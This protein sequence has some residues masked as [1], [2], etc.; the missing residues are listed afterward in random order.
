MKRYIITALCAFVVCWAWGQL[1]YTTRVAP[2]TQLSYN[3]IGDSCVELN[4]PNAEKSDVPEQPEVPIFYYTFILPTNCKVTSVEALGST[5]LTHTFPL[6]LKCTPPAMTTNGDIVYSQNND[7]PQYL[8]DLLYVVSDSYFDGDIHLVTIAYSPI[9]YTKGSRTLFFVRVPQFVVRYQN[10]TPDGI[11]PVTPRNR[12]YAERVAMIEQM[13]DNP[14]NVAAWI[15]ETPTVS[16][17]SVLLGSSTHLPGMGYEYLVITTRDLYNTTQKLIDWKR[18]KG[19]HAGVVCYED[20]RD[21]DITDTQTRYEEINDAA[22]HLRK[23]LRNAHANGLQYVFLVGER[24][25]IPYRKYYY[26]YCS[27][28]AGCDT[29]AVPTDFYYSELNSKWISK[30]DDQFNDTYDYDADDYASEIALGRLF[31]SNNEEWM[32]YINRLIT[33]ERNPGYGNPEYL[34]KYFTIQSDQMQQTN[35]GQKAAEIL[36]SYFSNIQTWEEEP[37]YDDTTLSQIYP[38]GKD[39]IDELQN[40]PCGYFATYAHGG[41]MSTAT[42]T[43]GIN[44]KGYHTWAIRSVEND[45]ITDAWSLLTNNGG[46]SLEPGAG[47]DRL[48]IPQNPFIVYSMSC[49]T[50][51]YDTVLNYVKSPDTRSY[52]PITVGVA[53]TAKSNSAIAYLGNTRVGWIGPSDNLHRA[54]NKEIL[55]GIYNLGLLEN[56]SK[57]KNISKQQYLSVAHNLLG[58][59]EIPMWT[60]IP[61]KITNVA[62]TDTVSVT[63]LFD[64]STP[65]TMLYGDVASNTIYNQ[66]HSIVK[67]KRNYYP[68]Y[69]PIK[70]QNLT[71]QSKHTIFGGD[72]AIGS[73]VK[74]DVAQGDFVIDSQGSLAIETTGNVILSS[75]TTIK[76]GGMLIIKPIKQ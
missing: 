58:C 9:M 34:G 15:P 35:S 29:T 21:M 6:P 38:K 72:V 4:F 8:T 33:Y 3:V 70:L 75:G 12:N 25:E 59:P 49:T 16:T 67:I 46:T 44:S 61:Q 52:N 14:Q 71:L 22:G 24:G 1:T 56:I 18:S 30:V 17:D 36:D 63:P 32:G 39:V 2:I 50:M 20:I 54:F 65:Q 27:S 62:D 37:S 7:T 40:N 42:F 64:N 66:N 26:S 23:Y 76:S 47:I 55:N 60:A 74:T 51:P 48:N 28:N 11:T 41:Q 31:V 53:F 10:G 43:G 19:I 57:V 68:F 69:L 5:T 13:V 73:N 45:T